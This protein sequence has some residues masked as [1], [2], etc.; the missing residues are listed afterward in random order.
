MAAVRIPNPPPVLAIVTFS[1]NSPTMRRRKVKSR[2]KKRATS[3]MLTLKVPKLERWADE[4]RRGSKNRIRGGTP[5]LQEDERENE[6][7][8]QEDSNSVVE[9]TGGLGIGSRDTVVGME[10]GRVGQPE[11]TV[12]GEGWRGVS[13]RNRR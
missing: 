6:P 11:S 12:R 1:V 5:H 7:R 13:V 9:L 10:E 2:K 8:G 3:A 4:V